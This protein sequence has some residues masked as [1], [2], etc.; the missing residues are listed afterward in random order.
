MAGTCLVLSLMFMQAKPEVPPS[1]GAVASKL[2]SLTES[3]QQIRKNQNLWRF[4]LCYS[5][6]YGTFISLMANSNF[7]VTS[8]GYSDI[9][10]AIN[11]VLLMVGGTVGSVLASL[12]LK[13]TG[14]YQ[15]TLRT[16]V[17]GAA[18]MLALLTLWLNTVNSKVGTSIIMLVMGFIGNPEMPICYQL[19]CELSLSLIHI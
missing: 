18:L 16:V 12:Y 4:F 3:F 1:E 5:V 19:G 9:E 10:I 11:I 13:K 15:K 17:I 7:I 6:H 2:Y 14:D 8:Y